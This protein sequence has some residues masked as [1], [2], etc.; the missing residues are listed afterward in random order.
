MPAAPSR[1]SRRV[2]RARDSSAASGPPLSNFPK[3]RRD[4]RS[5]GRDERSTSQGS[6]SAGGIRL[7][8]GA[9]RAAFGHAQPESLST[10]GTVHAGF[11]RKAKSMT[12]TARQ[13]SFIAASGSG[14]GTRASTSRLRRGASSDHDDRGN[15][16]DTAADETKV[17]HPGRE[18]V[19]TVEGEHVA[20]GTESAHVMRG[21]TPA[22]HVHDLQARG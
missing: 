2:N 12:S 10:V 11:S 8:R 3:V 1:Y 15:P 18:Q 21:P 5:S 19:R 20:S 16:H 4:S 7:E 22:T 13:H 6:G 17:V 14:E 9:A